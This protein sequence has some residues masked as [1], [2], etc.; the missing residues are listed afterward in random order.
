MSEILGYSILRKQL[1]KK[2]RVYNV[3]IICVRKGC[4][5]VY[6]RESL[7]SPESRTQ[8]GIRSAKDLLGRTILEEDGVGVG[9]GK[10]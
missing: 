5:C 6:E 10:G 4:A 3:A 8:N 1:K 2:S 9:A 7:G